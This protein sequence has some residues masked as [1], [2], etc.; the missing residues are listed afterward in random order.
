MLLV[1][2]PTHWYSLAAVIW[3]LGGFPNAAPDFETPTFVLILASGI[4]QSSCWVQDAH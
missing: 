1:L 4:F 2:V 3:Y